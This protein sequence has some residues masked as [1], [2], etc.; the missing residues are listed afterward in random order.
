MPP[1]STLI[2]KYFIFNF[3]TTIIGLLDVSAKSN[4][5]LSQLKEKISE[6]VCKLSLSKQILSY[7]FPG[8]GENSRNGRHRGQQATS[9]IHSIYKTLY[10]ANTKHQPHQIHS[11]CF[12][13]VLGKNISQAITDL[14]NTSSNR[15]LKANH[16]YIQ[17]HTFLSLIE[18]VAPVL[19]DQGIELLIFFLNTGY[20]LPKH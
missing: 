20:H 12:L 6:K 7:F 13:L 1:S 14:L 17:T 8:T 10:N 5:T 11:K 9:E 15:N 4:I 19:K 2:F 18:S 3:V 16:L